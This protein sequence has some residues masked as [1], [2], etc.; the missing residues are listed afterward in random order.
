MSPLPRRLALPAVLAAFTLLTGCATGYSS[1]AYRSSL[2][3]R[4]G[5]SVVYY[6]TYD[7]WG[8]FYPAP[9]YRYGSPP[10]YG[11]RYD[12]RPPTL[13]YVQPKP[14]RHDHRPPSSRPPD[15]RPPRDPGPVVQQDPP[16][17]PPGSQP[18]R[19]PHAEGERPGSGRD[20]PRRE[21]DTPRRPL[22]RPER[23]ERPDRATRP[24]RERAAP[25]LQGL[26]REVQRRDGERP[27]R[28][29]LP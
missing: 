2:D 18:P 12:P 6:D 20:R 17:L 4:G 14:P 25:P 21:S 15:R 19:P 5:S 29:R 22:D 24:D 7:P 23:G 26:P 3:A 10:P 8:P 9:Y 27:P 1:N 28:L 16:R 13:V 11:Y